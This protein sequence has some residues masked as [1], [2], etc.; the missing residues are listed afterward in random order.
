MLLSPALLRGERVLINLKMGAGAGPGLKGNPAVAL[1]APT[2][3]LFLFALQPFE[4]ATACDLILGR[5]ECSLEGSVY[6]LFSGRPITGGNH[7]S[8]IWF[9][10]VPAYLPSKAGVS[11]RDGEGSMRA[12]SLVDLL[13]E[14]RVEDSTPRHHF[15]PQPVRFCLSFTQSDAAKE[16]PP[17]VRS[18]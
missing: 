9:L 1:Y 10:R 11:W 12:G 18:R 17:L 7:E 14:L 5:A 3:G 4:G 16:Y 2:E 13:A 8:K 6:T 15:G